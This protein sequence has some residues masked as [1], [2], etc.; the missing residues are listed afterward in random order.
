MIRDGR[1]GAGS[2]DSNESTPSQCRTRPASKLANERAKKVIAQGK[3]DLARVGRQVGQ[4]PLAFTTKPPGKGAG[5]GVVVASRTIE[6]LGETLRW[7]NR[8]GGG[9]RAELVLPLGSLSLE[10]EA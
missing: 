2:P 10:A 1:S 9:M 4:L 7:E 8:I 5:L 6:R 3:F